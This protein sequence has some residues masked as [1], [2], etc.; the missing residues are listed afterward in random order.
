M[1]PTYARWTSVETDDEM[2]AASAV[3]NLSEMRFKKL[4]DLPDPTPGSMLAV[5]NGHTARVPI[6]SQVQMATARA[7][8]AL[9]AFSDLTV[10]AGVLRPFAHYSLIRQ[11][12]EGVALARW[13]LR[14]DKKYKRVQRS[15]NLEFTHD[16]DARDFAATLTRT[17]RNAAS[18]ALDQT[19]ARLNELKD[20]VSQLREMPLKRVPSWTNILVDISPPLGRTTSGHAPDSPVVVWKIASAF[21]HGSATTARMLSDLE[22]L[23]DFDEHRIASMELKPSWRVLAASYGTCVQMLYDLHERYEYLATHDYGKRVIGIAAG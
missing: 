2:E 23:T 22:Q 1:S 18:P 10:T 17:D 6:T 7:R 20:T 12:S 4:G 14:P 9:E 21:L 8:D 3:F 15:L 19:L 16:Q 11:A 5:E 13:L